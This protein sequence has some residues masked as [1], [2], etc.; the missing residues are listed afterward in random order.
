MASSDRGG[1]RLCSAVWLDSRRK[2]AGAMVDEVAENL[3]FR[4][5]FESVRKSGE[6]L[7]DHERTVC[8]RPTLIAKGVDNPVC[9]GNVVGSQTRGHGSI[10]TAIGWP[11]CHRSMHNASFGTPPILAAESQL[12]LALWPA[13]C[14]YQ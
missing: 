5:I 2:A 14:L 6:R 11:D 12:Y 4:T 8:V 3:L 9:G 7:T 10:P 1:N 13:K